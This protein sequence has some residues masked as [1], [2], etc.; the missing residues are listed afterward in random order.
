M[1]NTTGVGGLGGQKSDKLTAAGFSSEAT[2]GTTKKTSS[3]VIY[4]GD[5]AKAKAVGAAKTLG[6]STSN[7]EANDGTWSTAYDVL[8]VIGTDQE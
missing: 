5:A 1:V 4:N 2:T 3:Y 6:I 8:V 7:V